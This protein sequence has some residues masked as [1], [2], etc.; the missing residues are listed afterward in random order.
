MSFGQVDNL[1]WLI[2]DPGG[3][4]VM[5]I[6]HLIEMRKWMQEE[7]VYLYCILYAFQRTYKHGVQLDGSVTKLESQDVIILE[8]GFPSRNAID[9]DI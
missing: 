9:I 4:Q 5:F 6:I 8:N 7:K 2:Y 3:M 1:V